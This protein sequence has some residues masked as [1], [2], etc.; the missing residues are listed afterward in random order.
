[1]WKKYGKFFADWYDAHG[2]RHRKAFDTKGAAQRHSR[3]QAAAARAI[4]NAARP[5]ALR[6]SRKSGRART[7]GA[8]PSPR[9]S[10]S[11]GRR[12][13]SRA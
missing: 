1:M 4:K 9:K 13:R 10:P 7:T 12:S 11:T 3:K 2:K 8:E 5:A 6:S